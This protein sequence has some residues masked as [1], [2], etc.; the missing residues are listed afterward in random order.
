LREEI[1]ISDERIYKVNGIS[2]IWVELY[3]KYNLE[4]ELINLKADRYNTKVNK[5]IRELKIAQYE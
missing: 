1:E 3:P 5:L 4:Q 2:S